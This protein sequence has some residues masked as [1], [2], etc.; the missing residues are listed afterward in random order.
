MVARRRRLESS[1]PSSSDDEGG[2]GGLGG[3]GGQCRQGRQ[4]APGLSLERRQRAAASDARRRGLLAQVLQWHWSPGGPPGAWLTSCAQ[5][6]ESA[7]L[8]TDRERG[9]PCDGPRGRRRRSTRRPAVGAVMA[10]LRTSR[11]SRG[12]RPAPARGAAPAPQ[13]T[14]MGGLCWRRALSADDA[15]LSVLAARRKPRTTRPAFL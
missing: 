2:V 8:A 5:S 13:D 15:R 4:H 12:S 10:P 14:A 11:T 3:R 9:W 7:W 6:V 1:S